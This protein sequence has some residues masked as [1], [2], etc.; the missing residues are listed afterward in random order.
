M[1]LPAKLIKFKHAVLSWL[2]VR[3]LAAGMEIN[4]Q[5]IRLGHFDGKLWQLRSVRLEPGVLEEGRIKNRP[6]FIAALQ[7]LR[8]QR[9]SRDIFGHKKVTVVVS[10]SS[11]DIYNQLFELPITSTGAE[12]SKAVELNI[13]MSAPDDMTKLYSGW[14]IVGRKSDGLGWEIMSSF[15]SREVMDEVAEALAEVGFLVMAAEPRALSLVRIL[16]EKGAHF[17]DGKAFVVLAIDDVGM[18]YVVVRSGQLYFEYLNRWKNIAGPS[19]EISEKNFEEDLIT[20]LRQVMNFYGQH[21]TEPLSA[22]IVSTI[23][24]REQVEKAV[25][26]NVSCPAERLALTVG[27]PISSEWLI[28]LGCGLRGSANV[29]IEEINV[30]GDIWKDRFSDEQLLGFFGFWRIMIPIAFG[31]IAAAFWVGYS[32]LHS[33]AAELQAKIHTTGNADLQVQL[34]ALQASSTVFNNLVSEVA[35]ADQGRISYSPLVA[36]VFEAANVNG[37]TP[38]HVTVSGQNVT[39][40]GSASSQAKII[41]FKQALTT[42]QRF[43]GVDVPLTSIQPSGNN[44]TFTLTLTFHP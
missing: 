30:A 31:L 25:A 44:F 23:A 10:L 18:E 3:P 8:S 37:V 40:D 16:R 29:D 38:Q 7:S 12:L 32:F 22:V 19:G 14:Q 35:I 5:A 33:E 13:N 2:R 28:A 4:D 6:A 9:E 24:L 43:T 39:M 17:G 1:K 15:V 34:T 20:S 27:Q 36:G 41:A 26:E 21:W 42:N 11:L